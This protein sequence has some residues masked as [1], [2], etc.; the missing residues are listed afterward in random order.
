[1]FDLLDLPLSVDRYALGG[2]ELAT[3]AGWT[4]LSTLV[5]L[6]G[7]GLEGRGEDVTYQAPDARAFQARGPVLELAGTYTLEEFSRRLDGLQ[8]FPKPPADPKA[9]LYRRWAFES[10]ALDLALRQAGKS[11]PEAVGRPAQPMRFV[12]SL[13]LGSPPSLARLEALWER[14]SSLELKL[15]ADSSW[16]EALVSQ[17]RATGRVTTVDF[18]GQY[19]GPFKGTPP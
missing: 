2:L 11:F 1:M 3:K 13:G 6:Q 17:L 15:D 4:R 8:L 12:V 18:K 9:T 5:R 19:K 10:A 7:G 14:D 16:D